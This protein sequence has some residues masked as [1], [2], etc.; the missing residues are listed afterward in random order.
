MC[1]AVIANWRSI[2]TN[3]SAATW[4]SA[5]KFKARPCTVGAQDGI[6]VAKGIA[7]DFHIFLRQAGIKG[8]INVRLHHEGHDLAVATLTA[9]NDWNKFHARLVPVSTETNATLSIT[10][11]GPGTLWLDNAS[12]MPEDNIEGWRSDV[13]SAV[14][15]LRPGVIRFGGGLWTTQTW[16]IRMERHHRR[17]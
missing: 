1:G 4:P 10:F 3:L 12:L 7:C 5:S 9:G 8:P 16:R 17:S 15:E 6:A 13:V 2:E 14:K 11:D